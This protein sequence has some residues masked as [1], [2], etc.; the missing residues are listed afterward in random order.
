MDFGSVLGSILGGFGLHSG[1]FFGVKIEK[2]SLE[3]ELKSK[4]KKKAIKS[5][6][7]DPG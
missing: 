1:R 6:A 3:S 5:H 7:R 4:P 2:V